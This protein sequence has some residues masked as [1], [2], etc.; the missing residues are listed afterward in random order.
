MNSVL[1]GKI[2]DHTPYEAVYI[3]G[4]PDDSGISIG[5]ALYGLSRG[6][7]ETY[8]GSVCKH[9]FFGINYDSVLILKEVQK[10]KKVYKDLEA[11]LKQQIVAEY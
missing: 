9:N 1:N 3:G 2:L 6:R 11:L 5:S 7:N 8:A 10:R 4:S